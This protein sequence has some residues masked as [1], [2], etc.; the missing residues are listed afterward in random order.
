MGAP[1]VLAHLQTLGVRLYRDGDSLIAEP[2][3]ALTDGARALIREHK[4]ELLDALQ[5]PQDAPAIQ[6]GDKAAERKARALAFLEAHPN[7][8]R[9]CFADVESD[10]LNVVLTVAVREPWGAVEVLIDRRRFDPL[11]L[12]DLSLRHTDTSLFIPEH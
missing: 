3:S 8:K 5:R 9:A 7:V 6:A 12:M 1:D 10:P 2:R 4:S 11:A